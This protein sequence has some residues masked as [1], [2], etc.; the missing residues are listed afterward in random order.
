MKVF[1][2][3]LFHY[4]SN[5]KK[6]NYKNNEKVFNDITVYDKFYEQFIFSK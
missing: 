2:S 4:A 6:L 5:L 3:L 1:A